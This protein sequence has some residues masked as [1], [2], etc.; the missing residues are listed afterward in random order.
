M[1]GVTGG[2][3]AVQEAFKL[4]H[5]ERDRLPLAALSLTLIL[6]C[7]GCARLLEVFPGSLPHIAI[8]AC[9]VLSAMAFAMLDGVRTYGLRTIAVFLGICI[10]VGN[11]IENIGVITGFPYGH[12]RFLELMGP[13]ILHVP[14]L[15]GLA[16]VGM[17]YVSWRLAGLILGP[18]YGASLVFL[19]A[20][21]SLI[22]TAWDLAQ[23][24]V[25][26]TFLHGWIWRDGGPWFGVPVS[27]YL[28][29]LGTVFLIYVLFAAYLRRR[30]EGEVRPE[31]HPDSRWAVL[32][33]ALC[34]LG[35]VLEAVPHSGPG[36][37][38]D[39]TGR[40]WPVSE[41]TSA[42]ALVSILV[43]GCFV[44]LAWRSGSRLRAGTT[45]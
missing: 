38:A 45:D 40:L 15:L 18:A 9:D 27:N 5:A 30:R 42:A 6:A 7:Y 44:L 24:P 37:V 13:Q 14:V 8:V 41:I 34:A 16:Y 25:W 10:L 23:D 2:E 39:A 11:V 33:Y 26:S 22:M 4:R 29:W 36:T 32:F 35:N 17:A 28:G 20:L 12:Y 43:M 1:F 3:R 21:S 19:P 31:P